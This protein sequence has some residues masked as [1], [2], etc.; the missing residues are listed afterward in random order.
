MSD[1]KPNLDRVPASTSARKRVAKI[2]RGAL[3]EAEADVVMHELGDE[4]RLAL[5]HEHEDDLDVIRPRMFDLGVRTGLRVA[6]EQGAIS[7]LDEQRFVLQ[8]D[9][10][11]QRH[12]ISDLVDA[13]LTEIGVPR[14]VIGTVLVELRR[15][16]P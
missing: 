2:V 9:A 13:K 7:E 11:A 14:V 12:R 5:S 6:R 3:P 16:L 4:M 15:E 8:L 10:E 1:A